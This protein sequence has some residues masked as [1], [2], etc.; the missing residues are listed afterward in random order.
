M[1]FSTPTSTPPGAATLVSPNGNI[2]TGNPT[3]I[4]NKVSDATWYYLYLSGPSGYV[5]KEWYL[6]STVCG[7]STCSVANAAPGLATGQ[8]RWWIQT[9]NS[10]G[11]YGPWSTGMSFSPTL[12]AATTLVSPS[13]TTSD[14]T[15]LYTWSMVSGA[16]WYYLYV[17]GPSGNVI[18]T[19]YPASAVCGAST[20]SVEDPTILGSGTH[21]WWVQTWNNVG[22]GPW[23]TGLN[24]TV[25]A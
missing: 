2:T 22:Y 17:D 24:F 11:G 6:A 3:Y 12:P 1:S 9:W 16:T 23:S 19:W 8:H 18:Q 25:S 7:A 14:H 15:P 4:W 5:F 13:G 10:S 21:R 20:C